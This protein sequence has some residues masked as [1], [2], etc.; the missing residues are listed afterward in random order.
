[1]SVRPRPAD[2]VG[3]GL[4]A[5][6]PATAGVAAPAAPGPKAAVAAR[7]LRSPSTAVARGLSP[8]T[9]SNAYATSPVR[10][11]AEQRQAPAMATDAAG[12]EVP[13]SEAKLIQRAAYLWHVADGGIAARH[14]LAQ[15]AD[16]A[17]A[18]GSRPSIAR[19]SVVLPDPLGPS[20]PMNSLSP[21]DEINVDQHCPRAERQC[22]A[23][24]FNGTHEGASFS[25]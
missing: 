23:G 4:S 17:A 18:W 19:I 16:R 12:D 8:P 2:G 15:H 13:A 1:M 14:R 3:P 22:H 20:T 24:E 6:R 21:I 25:A 11:S 9:L 5:V 10:G 7:L